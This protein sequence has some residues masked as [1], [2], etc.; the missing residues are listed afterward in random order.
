MMAY[1]DGDKSKIVTGNS[2]R[3][4]GLF[5]TTTVHAPRYNWVVTRVP[6]GWIIESPQSSVRTFV[7]IDNEFDRWRDEPPN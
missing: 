1:H 5:D 7:P 2:L 6:G 3:K 4:M